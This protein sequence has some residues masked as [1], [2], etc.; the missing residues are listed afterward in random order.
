MTKSGLRV[1]ALLLVLD[2][3]FALLTPVAVLSNSLLAFNYLIQRL[4]SQFLPGPSCIGAFSSAPT[5]G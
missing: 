1:V 4:V 5:P 3:V 2:F